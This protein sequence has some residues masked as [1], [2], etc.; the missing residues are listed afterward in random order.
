MISNE[1]HKNKQHNVINPLT[2]KVQVV[3]AVSKIVDYVQGQGV[4]L[5]YKRSVHEVREHCKTNR[6]AAIECKMLFLRELLTFA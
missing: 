4:D 2:L 5:V 3:E 6:N 1:N